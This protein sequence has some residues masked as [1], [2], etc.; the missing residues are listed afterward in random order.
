ML[1][2]RDRRLLLLILLAASLPLLA[3]TTSSRAEAAE[4]CTSTQSGPWNAGATWGGTCNTSGTGFPGPG[5]TAIITNTT[6]PHNVT[7]TAGVNVEPAT[8]RLVGIGSLTISGA[9]TFTPTNI[10]MP[11]GKLDSTRNTSPASLTLGEAILTNDHTITPASFSKTAGPA[12][13][14]NGADV[15]LNNPSSIAEGQIQLLDETGDD[16]ALPVDDPSL[17]VNAPLTIAAATDS[18]PILST[19]GDDVPHLLINTGGS[20]SLIG[21]TPKT[22]GSHTRIAGGSLNVGNGQTMSLGR[23]SD[24][25]AG[26]TTVASGGTLTRSQAYTQSGGTTTIAAGGSSSALVGGSSISGGTLAVNGNLSGPVTLTGTGTLAGTGTVT[27]NTGQVTNTSGTVA[28][29]NSPGTLAITGN[30]TQGASRHP[31]DR[32]RR[33]DAGHA[34]RR[35]HGFGHREPRRHRRR[36]PRS[37]LP[38]GELGH[39]HLPHH[40]SPPETLSDAFA[41]VTSGT[42]S[43]VTG[44]GGLSGGRSLMLDYPPNAARLVVFVPPDGDGDGAPDSTDNC[45]T[46]SNPTQLDSDGDLQGDACDI[47]DDN[48]T[49]LDTTETGCPTTS[50][51]GISTDTDSDDDGVLDAPDVFPCDPDESADGDGDGVGS[52]GD[53]CPSDANPGQANLDGDSEGDICDADDDNDTV[54][55]TD[56]NC[57]A[58]E[59]A[60]TNAGCPEPAST[61]P[62]PDLPPTLPTIPDCS[63]AGK[64]SGTSGPDNLIGTAI[65]DLLEGAAGPDKVVGGDGPDCLFGQGG[66]DQLDGQNGNDVIRGGDGSD[67]VLGGEGDDTVSGGRGRDRF[68]GGNGNDSMRSVDGDSDRVNCGPGQDS[69]T[70]NPRDRVS[71]SCEK[72][73]VVGRG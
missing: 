15:V 31:R 27:G 45:L 17:Q 53:N 4:T 8:L 24:Q 44:G 30:Y 66:N 29:G 64:Q 5:D 13:I 58:T 23:P 65:G 70:V 3:L 32:S 38:A 61:M 19:D 11:G 22:I 46:V 14:Q 52:N 42:F 12:K 36:R 43:G 68:S 16:P 40:G 51:P 71:G 21:A 25:T 50:G 57:P 60:A 63:T 54:L 67:V 26:T 6:G 37:G 47:D 39:L 2:F 33:H 59:G 49:V 10:E 1:A 7:A 18:S 35:A 34:V 69:A 20:L 55:D 72:V 48:D 9:G 56:D 73:K 62:T 28:P 41:R